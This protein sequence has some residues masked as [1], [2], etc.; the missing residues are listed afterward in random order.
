[1]GFNR[2]LHL[3]IA[4]CLS[5]AVW[6]W[7]PRRANAFLA[8][9][10][11]I[12]PGLAYLLLP[13]PMFWQQNV[14]FTDTAVMGPFALLLLAIA[15][16]GTVKRPWAQV[17][18]AF[19]F[20]WGFATDWFFI[21]VALV[22]GTVRLAALV[23]T[24]PTGDSVSWFT[25]LSRELGGV[26]L[27]FALAFGFYGWQLTRHS[28]WQHWFAKLTL[29]TFGTGDGADALGSNFNDVVW[30][31]IRDQ[32]G[33]VGRVLLFVAFGVAVLH[34][35]WSLRLRRVSAV[36]EQEV[37][38]FPRTTF[39]AVAALAPLLHTY[40]L[41]NHSYLHDFSALKFAVPLACI[42][43]ALLPQGLAQLISKPRWLGALVIV[44]VTCSCLVYTQR[45]HIEYRRFVP[46]RNPE[47]AQIGE[48]VSRETR[49]EDVLF[50]DFA[51]A[52]PYPAEPHLL[53][54][55]MKLIHLVSDLEQLNSHVGAL[56]EQA[57]VVWLGDSN[58]AEEPLG[59]SAFWSDAQRIDARPY[60]LLRLSREAWLR[61][62]QD[63]RELPR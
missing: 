53:S 49:Y 20:L 58:R 33:L 16:D 15:M 27:S 39:L 55:T 13:G 10:S 47:I 50:S 62:V 48:F 44:A 54:H 52:E 45:L 36:D 38:T 14:Y 2:A 6:L 8:V 37:W 7:I 35:I 25:R 29:R 41:K 40:L 19:A 23:V 26:V 42:P 31:Y 28:L 3:F 24:K 61:K 60:Y 11:S 51:K 18:L 22:W 4:L 46:A 17:L 21:S 63:S 57:N 1:M 59:G 56:P 12:L 32:Y 34:L 9:L 30:G 43:F 5:F